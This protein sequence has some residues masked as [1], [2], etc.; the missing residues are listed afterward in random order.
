MQRGGSDITELEHLAQA[1]PFEWRIV[2]AWKCG[3]KISD[4]GAV[5]IVREP[6]ILAY[7]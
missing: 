1:S 4:Q 3:D 2:K 7:D 6:V 5:L